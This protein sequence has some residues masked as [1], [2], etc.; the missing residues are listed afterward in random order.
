M[1]VTG[2]TAGSKL[3]LIMIQTSIFGNGYWE[4]SF[5]LNVGG[6]GGGGG[7]TYLSSKK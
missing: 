1:W 4:N 7:G 5:T 6:V 2:N 3:C